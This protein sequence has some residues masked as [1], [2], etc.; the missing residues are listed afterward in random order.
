MLS[1]GCTPGSPQQTGSGIDATQAAAEGTD[2]LAEFRESVVGGA[3]APPKPVRTSPPA[4]NDFIALILGN[5]HIGGGAPFPQ[6]MTMIKARPNMD[7]VEYQPLSGPFLDFLESA[8]QTPSLFEPFPPQYVI[9]QGQKYSTSGRNEYPIDAAIRMVEQFNRRGCRVLLMP[10]WRTEGNVGEAQRVSKIYERIADEA[11]LER[12]DVPVEVVPVGLVWDRVL[13]E[14]PELELYAGDGNH[15][16]NQGGYL[17]ALTFYCWLYDAP[18]ESEVPESL[19]AVGNRLTETA[20]E[21]CRQY[22]A[23]RKH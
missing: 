4:E 7:E 3:A 13:D 5:S 6:L 22:R 20:L 18:P 8:A 1:Q 14:M 16:G 15:A 11:K 9:L 21:V 23:A 2:P 19:Q 10:E 12:P 17:T